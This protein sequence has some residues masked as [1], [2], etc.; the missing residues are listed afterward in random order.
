MTPDLVNIQNGFVKFGGQII[1]KQVNEFDLAQNGILVLKNLNQPQ[2]LPKIRAKGA[3]RPYRAQSDASNNGVKFDDRVI[4]A[5][6]SKWDFDYDPEEYRN[7]YLATAA[8]GVPYFQFAVEQIG[9]EYLAAIN[10]VTAYFGVRNPAGTTAADIATGWGTIIAQETAASNI[11]VSSTGIITIDDAVEQVEQ[12]ARTCP[13]WMRRKGFDIH[14]SYD[15]FNKYSD[16]YRKQFGFKYDPE[17]DGTYRIDGFN[18]VKLIAQSFLGESQRIIASCSN[19]LVMGTDGDRISVPSSINR[20]IIEGRAMMPVGF[21]IAD[22][23]AI[24]V[25]DQA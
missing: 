4:T 17:A 22:L 1:R 8:P 21:Q 13:T 3:P 25:N 23:E 2:V 19:N 6:Q 24:F 11:E 15:V 9:T 7:T 20:N 16:S 12:I 10:D 18:K 14:V 5:Y